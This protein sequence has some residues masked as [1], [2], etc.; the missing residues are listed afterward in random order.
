[1]VWAI[2]LLTTDLSTRS[3]TPVRPVTAFG[4]WLGSVAL[5]RP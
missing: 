2:S 1:M 3:L 5:E 4:V